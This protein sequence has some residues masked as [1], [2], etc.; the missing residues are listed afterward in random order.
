MTWKIMTILL[1]IF[2]DT[3]A[4][5]LLRWVCLYRNIITYLL[6]RRGSHRICAETTS[7]ENIG[8][9]DGYKYTYTDLFAAADRSENRT[10]KVLI[11]PVLNGRAFSTRQTKTRAL[12]LFEWGRALT[13]RR[14]AADAFPFRRPRRIDRRNARVFLRNIRDTGLVRI[15]A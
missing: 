4:M 3:W 2:I 15:S 13:V 1:Y 11:G 5:I 9:E 7:N 10:D 8:N 6:S 12:P 14:L